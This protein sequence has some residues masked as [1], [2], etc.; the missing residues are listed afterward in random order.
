[1]PG[2]VVPSG[3]AFVGSLA[4]VLVLAL[5]LVAAAPAAAPPLTIPPPPE[6]STEPFAAE[7]ARAHLLARLGRLEESLAAYR[8]LLAVQ[9]ADLAAREEYAETLLEA[10]LPERAET[11]ITEALRDDPRSIRLRRLQARVDLDRKRP[12]VAAD[13][14]QELRGW[15]PR[16]AGLLGDLAQAELQDGHWTRALALYAD[17]LEADPETEAARVAHRELRT[18]YA[19]RVEVLHRTLLQAAATSHIEEAAWRGWLTETW[20]L[21]GGVRQAHY[22][23]D[24]VPA[25]SIGPFKEDVQTLLLALGLRLT[26]RWSA[27]GGLEESV[28]GERLRTTLR[29]GGAFD[30]GQATFASLD[31]ALR[32]LLT[33]PVSAVTRDGTTDRLTADVLR[34]VGNRATVGGRYEYRHYRARGQSLGDD[35]ELSGRLEIELLRGPLEVTLGPQL[36][37]QE[38]TPIAGSPLRE[39]ISFIRRQRVVA[40]GLTIG[41][42]PWPGLRVQVG[43]VGRRDWYRALTSYEVSGELRWRIHRRL[44]FQ[45]LYTRNSEGTR[46]GG[47]EES[48]AG[49]LHLLY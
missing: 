44:E 33:N 16:D 12:R 24:A 49:S 10:G 32:D 29:L 39:Q 17:I 28:R 43:A 41:G 48:F 5:P 4:G 38:Y 11:V 27:R 22:V 47:K 2:R 37:F 19:P 14:L 8:A 31:V 35:W 42:E 1:M 7:R 46:V 40:T 3:L 13:R 34:R 30:D 26:P 6:E 20:W 36:F 23:Q 9:P 25:S 18:T 21:R 15:A 45:L